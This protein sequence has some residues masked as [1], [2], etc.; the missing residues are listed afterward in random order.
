M[1]WNSLLL[2]FKAGQK[3][4]NDN[5]SEHPTPNQLIEQKAQNKHNQGHKH[6]ADGLH[7]SNFTPPLV[8]VHT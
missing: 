6:N 5:E 1:N 7:I 3:P 8:V 4:Q 2:F